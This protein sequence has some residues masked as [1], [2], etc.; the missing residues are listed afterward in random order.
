MH[1]ANTKSALLSTYINTVNNETYALFGPAENFIRYL[2]KKFSNVYFISQPMPGEDDLVVTL[3]IYREGKLL[4]IKKMPKF[5]QL[6]CWVNTKKV[7]SN[8]TVIRLKIRDFISNFYFIT[9]HISNKLDLFIGVESINSLAAVILKKFGYIRTV[10]YFSNDYHTKRYTR[11]KN[12]LFLKLD[13]IAAYSSDY[14]WMMNPKIHESRIERGL[15]TSKLAPHFIIHGGL[16]F[17][18]GEPLPIVEREKNRI[19]YATRA[20]HYGLEIILQAFS[21]VFKKYPDSSI[22]ITGHADK[23]KTRISGL[24][25]KLKI[26]QH[27]VFTGF[28]K[29]EELNHLV[30]HSYIG[31]A[32]WSHGTSSSAT[33]GDPEKIRRYFHFGLPVVSTGNAFTAEAIIKHSA[34]IVVSDKPES[35]A[36]AIIKLFGDKE[37]YSKCAYASQELGRFYKENNM[38][39]NS[40]E[41]LQ[42]KSL[43]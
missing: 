17:F 29:E 42:K 8:Q 2:C 40:L 39:D 9:F 15:K 41:D 10:L 3:S 20:G 23:E 43:L 21:I 30:R 1:K 38:L 12:W 31:L 25:E 32:I 11:L 16:P 36:E 28:I 7:T 13:E 35:V 27:I 33:Y 34:G 14:I 24:I 4:E 5:L 26:S 6:L 19:V 37:L 18:P 22:Y